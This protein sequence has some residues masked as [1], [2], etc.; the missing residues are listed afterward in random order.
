MKHIV[1]INLD[2][3]KK[4]PNAGQTDY[5]IPMGS[6]GTRFK[7]VFKDGMV[8]T[9]QYVFS[10]DEERLV[11]STAYR[12]NGK[13]RNPIPPESTGEPLGPLDIE[14]RLNKNLNHLRALADAELKAIASPGTEILAEE[15]VE[16]HY[17][18]IHSMTPESEYLFEHDLKIR[19]HCKWCDHEA[20]S[21]AFVSDVFDDGDDGETYV[22]NI[23]PG[24]GEGDAIEYEKLANALKRRTK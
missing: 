14:F 20:S 9:N 12:D 2:S 13:K 17:E 11:S 3:I 19:V 7:V 4:N 8:W 18:H 15:T 1:L 21:G 23:C 10:G 6:T 24:C 16:Y 22:T 5:M